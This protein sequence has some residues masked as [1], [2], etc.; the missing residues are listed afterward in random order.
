MYIFF[1]AVIIMMC[2]YFPKLKPHFFVKQIFRS[3]FGSFFCAII[4][5]NSTPI[6]TNLG[7]LT[8]FLTNS[9]YLT[10]LLYL[11]LLFCVNDQHNSFFQAS[12]LVM[13]I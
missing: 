11:V 4:I 10:I 6:N 9:I 3:H 13:F 12:T 8:M 5:L 1:E 7:Y 2:D